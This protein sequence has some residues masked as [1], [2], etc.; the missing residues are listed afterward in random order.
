MVALSSTKY[1]PESRRAI[2]WADEY[3]GS[4]S[5]RFCCAGGEG[6]LTFRKQGRAQMLLT[7]GVDVLGSTML[8]RLREHLGCGF[9]QPSAEAQ[10][11]AGEAAACLLFFQLLQM[12]KQRLQ[13]FRAARHTLAGQHGSAGVSV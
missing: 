5:S 7:P 1:V 3:P 8:H 9:R 12:P 6:Q 2:A 10:Q 4:P 13:H 11:Q